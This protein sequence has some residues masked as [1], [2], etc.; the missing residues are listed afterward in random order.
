MT[1]ESLLRPG[2]YSNWRILLR[3][4]SVTAS[5]ALGW[6]RGPQ[7]GKGE[8]AR[9]RE[10]LSSA[11]VRCQRPTTT[12]SFAF[13]FR[14]QMCFSGGLSRGSPFQPKC[15]C[16]VTVRQEQKAARR[17]KLKRIQWR[18]TREEDRGKKN[19]QTRT[20]KS[21]R[22]ERRERERAI[23]RSRPWRRNRLARAR[24]RARERHTKI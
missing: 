9:E 4:S 7:C 24:T 5:D 6:E 1:L 19:Q 11:V 22:E 8:A 15:S 17:E 14:L 16:T 18:G 10:L 23:S 20:R 12:T 21:R 2:G 13:P 3:R